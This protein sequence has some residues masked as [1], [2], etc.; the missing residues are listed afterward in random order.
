[1][2]KILFALSTMLLFLT[3]CDMDEHP[4]AITAETL[5][6]SEEGAQQLVTGIYAIFWDNWMMEQTYEAWMDQ[7][8]DHIGA[9]SWVLSS[10]GSGVVTGHY[11]YNTTNDLWSSFYRM[12]NRSNKAMEA[13]EGA[14]TYETDPAVS[15]LYGEC[16]FLRAFAYF[17]LVR[18]YGGV[19][20]RL[21]SITDESFPRSTPTEVYGQITDDLEKSLNYLHYQSEG[22]VGDWGHA[23]K[24]AAELLLARVYC[25]MGSCALADQQVKMI[26]NIKG[27]DTE[28]T[29]N[30]VD[31]TSGIDANA[32]YTRAKELCDKII[33]RKGVDFDL[34]PSYNALWGNGNRKNKEI[35]WGVNSS[36]ADQDFQNAGLNYYMT[37]APW[38]GAG[39]WM[40]MADNLYNQF[41][42]DDERIV[43][44]IW[45]YYMT[46]YSTSQKWVS[47][48]SNSTK[49][50]LE[51]MP[52][53]L[54]GFRSTF[55][56][57]Y[58]NGVACMRKWYDGDLNNPGFYTARHQYVDQDI[59]LLRF[60]EAY[61]L[62]AEA[63]VELD[64]ISQAMADVDVIRKRAKATTYYTG[65][66]TD[67]V[68]A[69]SMVMKE[70]S[71][72][73]AQ[74]FNRKFDLLRWGLYLDV[75][76]TT[77][78]INCGGT[79]RSLVRTEK[80]LLYAIPTNEVATNELLG[81]NNYG[82]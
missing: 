74:E 56:S 2:K 27:T 20:L 19:P 8:H 72:E 17:H 15:Q 68:Q 79:N 1:M 43:D 51:N 23:D 24:T 76:N 22:N 18:M 63:E 25:T 30:P 81:G 59:P 53:S 73:L 36:S 40:Y 48:P 61:L 60:A 58:K 46:S 35:V 42:E 3:A 38:G 31:G 26:V 11:A 47:Y 4:Y 12:I 65:V 32:C 45:H 6:E 80:N 39:A 50:N 70:R 54:K 82:Y 34:M 62:R 44:G 13:L 49:Y 64:Q 37:P 16:L 33:S 66:V 5:A 71:L 10:A 29:C 14:G 55:N 9:P 57:S 21:A 41:D 75:M 28:F 52:E 67:K 7:D 78:F 77:Q 69:R